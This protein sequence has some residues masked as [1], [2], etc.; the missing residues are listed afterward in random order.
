MHAI[1]IDIGGTQVKGVLINENGTILHC[2]QRETRQQDNSQWKNRVAEV[3]QLLQAISGSSAVPLGIAAPGLASEGNKSITLMPGRLQGLENFIWSDFLHTP[4]RV[5]NDAHAA[6]I[7]EAGFGA[8][9]GF[10]HILLLTLG[11]G[12]GGGMMIDGHLHQGMLNRAG[13][14]GHVTLDADNDTLDITLMPAS[15]EDAIGDCTIQ[16]RSFGKFK[17]TYDLIQAYKAEETLASFVWLHS[18]KRLSVAL[19]SF[20][21]MVSP[22]II[23]LGGGI[24]LAGDALFKP[25]NTFM[26]IFEWRIANQRT[27]VLPT[28]L[29]EYSGAV[30][31]AVFAMQSPSIS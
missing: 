29:N 2:V 20:I 25:L 14:L 5:L 7:A 31:A 3:W 18:V 19:C 15:L 9:K 30:G 12:V 11:T 17:S 22:E 6:L 8:G 28:V 16:Q 21:N 1:G 27:P 23:I 10:R 24:S 13:H 26:D 4:T